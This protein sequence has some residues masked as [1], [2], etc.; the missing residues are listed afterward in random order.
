[1]WNGKMKALTFTFDDGV[2]EDK[3][4]CE[5]LNKYK[6][7]GTFNII[8]SRLIKR[9]RI[10]GDKPR[11][12]IDDMRVVYEGH[13]VAMHTYTHPFLTDLKRESIRYEVLADRAKIRD[14]L[15]RD[16][17]GIVYPMG[18]Y[19]ETVLEVLSELGVRYGRTNKSTYN[20][21]LPEPDQ[22]LEWKF[23]CRHHYEHIF[24]LAERFIAL[25]PDRPQLFS[26]MGHSYEFKT[27]EDW[28]RI[29]RFCD[30]VANRDD[31]FYGTNA[32]CLMLN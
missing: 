20:F 24:E 13:E 14:E 3:R 7:K 1:M 4:L 8:G 2:Y 29:E 21:D 9:E 15:D 26:V 11:L 19:N 32:E 12:S 22:L 16:P 18:A 10:K 30:L 5:I 27:E 6:M 17:V 28:A 31:I 23:T 25:K